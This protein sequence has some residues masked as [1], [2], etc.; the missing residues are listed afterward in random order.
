[1]AKIQPSPHPIQCRFRY[2]LAFDRIYDSYRDV[3]EEDVNYGLIRLPMAWALP[4][5]EIEFYN[6]TTGKID[7]LIREYS[8]AEWETFV[9]FELFPILHVFDKRQEHHQMEDT[10]EHYTITISKV[11]FNDH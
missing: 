7:L 2:Y 10:L 8:Q 9:A 4:G 3:V 6:D 11:R 5:S 1:M